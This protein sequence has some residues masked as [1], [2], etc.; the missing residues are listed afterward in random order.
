MVRETRHLWVGNLP[1]NVGDD[2]LRNYFSRFGGVES[3]RVLPKRSADGGRA[4]FV[5]FIDI[6]SAVKAHEA[7]HKMGSRELRTNY[8]E[9][10]TKFTF[11]RHVR[12]GGVGRRR[13]ERREGDYEHSHERGHGWNQQSPETGMEYGDD[14]HWSGYKEHGRHKVDRERRHRK[15]IESRSVSRSRSRSPRGR[16]ISS[17]RSGSSEAVGRSDEMKSGTEK[18]HIGKTEQQEEKSRHERKAG[19]MSP[20]ASSPLQDRHINAIIVENLDQQ[21]SERGITEGLFHECKKYGEVI[22]VR[23]IVDKNEMK[24]VVKF[25]SFDEAAQAKKEMQGRKFHGNKLVVDIYD[26]ELSDDNKGEA[27]LQAAKM[28][29]AFTP[30]TRNEEEEEYDMAATRTLWIGNLNVEITH[31]EL[32]KLCERYGEVLDMDIKKQGQPFMYAFVRYPDLTSACRAKRK[33]DN[34]ALLSTRLKVGFGKPHFSPALFL[35]NIGYNTSERFIERQFSS[36]GRLKTV[37]INRETDHAMVVFDH[38]DSAVDANKAMRGRNFSRGG[39]LKIDFA[40]PASQQEFFDAMDASHQGD[41]YHHKEGDHLDS[42]RSERRRNEG[43]EQDFSS[44][45]RRHHR[46]GEDKDAA[47]ESG[48]G[49]DRGESERSRRRHGRAGDEEWM[50]GTSKSSERSVSRMKEKEGREEPE[51]KKRKTSSSGHDKKIDKHRR[52]SEGRNREKTEKSSKSDLTRRGRL[53]KDKNTDIADT[54]TTEDATNE[55]S[56]DMNTHSDTS[57]QQTV[58]H[59]QGIA[60]KLE[61]G[62][63]FH[64]TGMSQVQQYSAAAAAAAGFPAFQ[65]QFVSQA[66]TPVQPQAQQTQF[67]D[68]S[69]VYQTSLTQMNASTAFVQQQALD[70]VQSLLQRYPVVWQ[71]FLALKDHQI[72]VQMHHLAGNRLMADMCLPHA[73]VSMPTVVPQLKIGQRM[74]L[75]PAQLDVMT[76]RMQSETE[77]CLLLALPCGRDPLDVHYQTKAMGIKFINYLQEKQAA[78]IINIKPATAG[79]PV[80]EFVLHIF[81]PCDFSQTYLNKA[82]QELMENTLQNGHLMIL[83]ATM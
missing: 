5:D 39:R 52:E 10:G 56:G 77:H 14:S 37:A 46:R 23:L 15:P 63:V 2:Q 82:A 44:Q 68:P 75:E 60:V 34:H 1:E 54:S 57:Q 69:S 67:F 20:S 24:A 13:F 83:I 62:D 18:E 7:S 72:A 42:H 58:V 32:R 9:P 41:N 59:G 30:P 65:S 16:S 79:Q 78:G 26:G 61:S 35:D 22:S 40:S 70:P 71:G 4:S 11:G 66:A 73:P 25:P 49:G 21:S 55:M 50:N 31:A 38:V 36:F 81:P 12:G 47:H 80:G 6:K 53:R 51:T 48:D 27:I 29:R 33:L 17:S 76:K 45:P 64:Q 8:N 19:S 3:V 43:V 28:K 74:K